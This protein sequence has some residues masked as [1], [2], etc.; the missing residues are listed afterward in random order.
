MWVCA[1]DPSLLVVRV[2]EVVALRVAAPTVTV[3]VCLLESV[4]A[5]TI[6][7]GATGMARDD[8][9]PPAPPPAP[10]PRAGPPPAAPALPPAAPPWPP[11]PV[12]PPLPFP[13]APALPPVP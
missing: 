10:A 5:T 6:C 8:P 4:V 3:C 2:C 13:P 12:D 7:S 9:L 1:G 11:P